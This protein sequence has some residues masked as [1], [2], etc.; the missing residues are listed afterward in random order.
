MRK[1]IPS[2]KYQK[3]NRKKTVF[4]VFCKNGLLSETKILSHSKINPRQLF[5]VVFE[6]QPSELNQK[7]E[8]KTLLFLEYSKELEK[9]QKGRKTYRKFSNEQVLL[10]SR[11]LHQLGRQI[12]I[13][14]RELEKLSENDDNPTWNSYDI[15]E[16]KLTPEQLKISMFGNLIL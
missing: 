4:D 11:Y 3:R 1:R 15:E 7:V 13:T 12:I 14:A 9:R 8:N 10:M 16:E 5:E 2:I 6:K